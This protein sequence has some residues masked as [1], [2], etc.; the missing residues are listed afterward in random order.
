MIICMMIESGRKVQIEIKNDK[1]LTNRQIEYLSLVA[2]G[3]KNREIALMLNVSEST[4]KK[5]LEDIFKRLNAKDRT[6]AV[7]IAFIHRILNIENLILT[8]KRYN[9]F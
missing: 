8:I 2:L 6:N 5:I 9:V 1:L 3:L 7:T 4:V